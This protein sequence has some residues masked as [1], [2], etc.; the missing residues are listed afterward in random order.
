M[1]DDEFHELK[2]DVRAIKQCLLGYDGQAGVCKDLLEVRT[3]F[4]NFKRWAIGVTC[5][6]VGTG[7]IS[8]SVI[9]LLGG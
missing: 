2:E 7:V 4:F 3:E 8:L 1:N 5:F 9:K 6:L